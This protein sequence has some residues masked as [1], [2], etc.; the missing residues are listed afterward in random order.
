MKVKKVV[1]SRKLKQYEIRHELI[2][3]SDYNGPDTLMKSAYTHTGHYIGDTKLAHR[4]CITKNLTNLQKT[5]H[6]HCVCSI[7]FDKKKQKWYG[8]SHR[9]ICGFGIGDKIFEGNFGDD[10]TLFVR[11]GKKTVKSMKEAKLAASRFASYVS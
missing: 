3:G 10:Q 1:F 5:H 7:G 8:W 11:H 4:L 2:D 9:A 6:S